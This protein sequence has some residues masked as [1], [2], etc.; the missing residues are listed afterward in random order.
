MPG[1]RPPFLGQFLSIS[2]P[3]PFVEVVHDFHYGQNTGR[4]LSVEGLSPKAELKSELDS[5]N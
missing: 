3:I 1:A 4:N 5:Q 2:N